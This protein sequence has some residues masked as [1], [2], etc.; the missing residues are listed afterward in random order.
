MNIIPEIFFSIWIKQYWNEK[1]WINVI[2]IYK[3][4]KN[5][6]DLWTKTNEKSLNSDFDSNLR[7]NKW[8]PGKLCPKTKT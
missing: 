1:I 6:K 8:G 2:F 7:P 5:Y 3:N 4:H